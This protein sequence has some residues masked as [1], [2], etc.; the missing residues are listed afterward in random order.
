MAKKCLKIHYTVFTQS[1]FWSHVIY[2][3]ATLASMASKA[4][5]TIVIR[6]K[7]LYL[8]RREGTA[9]WQ[10]H[11]KLVAQKK[12]YR[13][14]TG[15]DDITTATHAAEDFMAEVRVAERRG[16]PVV[17][18]KFKAV[19]EIVMDKIIK[20]VAAG[21]AKK[22]Y[23]Q[24]PAI[25]DRYLVPFFGKHNIDAID[26]ALITEFSNWRRDKVGRELKKSTQHTHN[27]V[28]A[29]IFNEAVDMKYMTEATR[30]KLKNT[31]EEGDKRGVFTTDEL[32]KLQKFIAKWT[33]EAR[34]E[35]SKQLRELLALYV[36]F[37]ASTGARPGTELKDLT[38]KNIS[39]VTQEGEQQIHIHVPKGKI[40][41]PRNMIG[42]FELW[43]A[44][45]GLKNLQKEFDDL[46][47]DELVAKKV[48]KPIFRMR[49]GKQPYNFVNAFGD[50]LKKAG[51]LTN[52]HDTY[53]RSLYSLRHYYATERINDGFTYE[54]L[55][56]QMGTSAKM[57]KDH[58]KHLKVTRMSKALAG[59]NRGD[60][61]VI[62]PYT[63]PSKA[64]MMS[65]LGATLGV[66]LPFEEQNIDATQELKKELVQQRNLS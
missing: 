29:K 61:S 22:V 51:M 15:T 23:A 17:S 37:V 3:F 31:G 32:V 7:L 54:K 26:N 65:L 9:N 2:K 21:H 58:Y 45:E 12:W 42:H 34:T 53:E 38:W 49:N 30:P 40:G 10:I 47:L 33:N 55:E 64:N 8:V 18:K 24:Y 57:L 6:P 35:D 63:Y 59:G 36:T 60:V 13:K 44:L 50:A 11:C 43:R 4:A 41:K 66:Y 20:L 52:G 39:Y 14:T 19:A 56:E 48:D 5:T 16:Y 28:L 62:G 46:T 27:L 25:I 1:V